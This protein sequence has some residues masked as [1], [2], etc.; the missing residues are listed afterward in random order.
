MHLASLGISQQRISHQRAIR[1]KQSQE[2][3]RNMTKAEVEEDRVSEYIVM[4]AAVDIAFNKW[5]SSLQATDMV[6]V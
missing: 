6:A 1:Q 3:L 4:P 5:W 2:P